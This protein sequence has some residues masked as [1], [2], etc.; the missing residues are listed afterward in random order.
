MNLKF[1]S[2]L[3]VALFASGS[4]LL[5]DG[6]SYT[7]KLNQDAVKGE[8]SQDHYKVHSSTTQ[9]VLVGGKV[10]QE[11]TKE[12]ETEATGV[13]ETME[14]SP[15]HKPT[16]IKFTVEKFLHKTNDES[17][18]KLKAGA[19]I[20]GQLGEDKKPTFTVD[21]EEPEADVAEALALIF[22]MPPDREKEVDEDTVFNTK[23]PHEVG[24]TW[25][26]N[27]AAM[28]ASMP[29]EMPFEVTEDEAKG[30]VKFSAVKTEQGLE[31]AQVK[32]EAKMKP[33][34]I[35]GMPPELKPKRSEVKVTEEKL[36]PLDGKTPVL[37][38][39]QKFDFSFSGTIATPDGQDATIEVGTEVSRGLERKL[40]K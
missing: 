8:K 5:A 40:L 15:H 22:E 28:I 35:K 24:T 20:I 12:I 17:G 10:A 4:L 25:S 13:L 1:T 32:I 31:C 21:G 7:L 2:L 29:E 3:S 38:A 14:V 19:V 23:E 6:K 37:S 30:S 18:S 33:K 39:E 16:Q 26:A 27:V 11:E 34:K 36:V 9:K